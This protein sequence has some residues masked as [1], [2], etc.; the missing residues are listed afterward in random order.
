MK[1]YPFQC[2]STISHTKKRKRG[3][4][5]DCLL[6]K[7][8]KQNAARTTRMPAFLGYPPPPH[9]YPYYWFTLDPKSKEDKVKVTNLKNLPKFQIFEYWKKIHVTHL[10][11]LLDRMCKYAMDP[12]IDI[13]RTQFCP[14]MD[15]WTDRQTRWNQC[16]PFPLR[17]S[18]TVIDHYQIARIMHP[19]NINIMGDV[20]VTFL[21]WNLNQIRIYVM[22]EHMDAYLCSVIPTNRIPGIGLKKQI[23][24]ENIFTIF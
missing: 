9:D 4:N 12:A 17:W 24:W 8:C 1:T 18:L 19:S 6:A 20:V 13:E 23:Y 22:N 2:V 15:R 7:I 11:K 14:Q 21:C 10:L 3:A 5:R 16:A